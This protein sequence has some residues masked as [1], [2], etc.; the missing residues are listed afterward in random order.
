MP[1]IGALRAALRGNPWTQLHWQDPGEETVLALAEY[2]DLLSESA[3]RLDLWDTEYVHVLPDANAIVEWVKGTALRPV[4][5]PLPEED[6]G[7]FLRAYTEEILRA[8]PPRPDG[9]VLFPFRR[10]FVV[11]YRA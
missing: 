2:Y 3:T 4:L 10:R 7:R 11:A 1:W 8:Y 5:N 9:R 6:R